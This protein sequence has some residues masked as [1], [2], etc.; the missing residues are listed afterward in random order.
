MKYRP[1]WSLLGL[2]AILVIVLFTYPVWR[3]V[4]TGRAAQ[5]SFPAASDAQREALSNIGKET[6]RDAA[7]TAY[8]S[9]LT[10]V[11]AP[12][13]EQPTPVLPDAQVI[14]VGDF[15]NLD[16][17]R[18]AKGTVTLYRSADSSLL[19]R[20]DDFVAVNGPNLQVYLAGSTD[21]KVP[22]D[23]DAGG[24]SR[25]PVGPLKGSQGNQQY[26][27]PKELPIARY[28]SVV[29][30]SDTLKLIYTYATFR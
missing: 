30:Y 21:P 12:T 4:L 14:R 22:A 7:A 2:G 6:S 16:A 10:V 1:Q 8:V 26:S 3:K 13:S 25:F 19:L 9:I 27:I 20:F 15:L 23:L 17:L 29:I 28:K 18:T 24:V 5:G 11:P